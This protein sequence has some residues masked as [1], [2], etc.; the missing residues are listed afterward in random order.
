MFSSSI[1]LGIL[2][3][4]VAPKKNVSGTVRWYGARFNWDHDDPKGLMKW[5]AF[6]SARGNPAVRFLCRAAH[7][8]NAKCA[9]LRNESRLIML[10]NH[11]CGSSCSSREHLRG[12]IATRAR[13][14]LPNFDRLPPPKRGTK[15][16]K[17]LC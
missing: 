16:P 3:M 17:P 13:P 7:Y 9:R 2:G 11:R 5:A 1:P 10:A 8:S 6:A 4:L 14:L 15:T 12:T